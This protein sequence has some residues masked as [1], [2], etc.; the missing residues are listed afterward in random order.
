ML[1][2]LVTL[3]ALLACDSRSSGTCWLRDIPKSLASAD[4]VERG[5]AAECVTHIAPDKAARWVPALT[6]LLGDTTVYRSYEYGGG[7]IGFGEAGTRTVNVAMPTL[8]AI[9]RAS[10]RRE[11]IAPLIEALVAA[12]NQVRPKMRGSALYG[13]PESVAY[14]LIELLIS[15]YH[16]A[17][18]QQTLIDT[19][20]AATPRLRNAAFWSD[21]D[22]AREL[23][24]LYDGRVPYPW[25]G[26]AAPVE[27]IS[28]VPAGVFPP[29]QSSVFT[30]PR[31]VRG[32][33]RGMTWGTLNVAG[34]PR[35][36]TYLACDGAPVEPM[37]HP[38]LPGACDP[39][40]GDTLC[41]VALPVL[42]RHA[43]L[44]EQQ[45]K[46]V[47]SADAALRDRI[48]A[49]EYSSTSPI[50]GT[51]LRAQQAG[52]AACEAQMGS[53]W[54]MAEHHDIDSGWGAIGKAGRLTKNSRYWVAINDQ[55]GNCWD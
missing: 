45:A 20:R 13:E 9:E 32:S 30:R 48:I 3:C 24:D 18:L 37:T 4:P 42:C 53:G 44:L 8:R 41:T 17:G 50:A 47:K 49:L 34:V 6:R 11:N 5:A 26:A 7:L 36:W 43:L 28:R 40:T 25:N 52:D 29:S 10:P 2:A 27:P 54:R 51:A 14:S 39:Y 38:R 19:I 55:S 33:G 23:S 46:V 21:A 16:D 15:R 12:A 1:P 35:S 31:V 22:F